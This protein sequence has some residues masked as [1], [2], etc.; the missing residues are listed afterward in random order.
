MKVL[1]VIPAR[2]PSARLPGKP[3]III[4]G[5]TLLQRVYEQASQSKLITK[6]VIS[7]DDQRIIDHAKSFGALA[8]KTSDT[9]ISGSDR[10]AET[11]QILNQ[12]GEQFDLIINIQGDLPLIDPLVIDQVIKNFSAVSNNFDLGTIAKKL[13]DQ[14]EYNRSSSVK[15]SISNSNKALYFSRAPIPLI[16]DNPGQLPDKVYHHYGLYIFTPKALNAFKSLPPGYLESVEGLE[17]LRALENDLSIHVQTFD[18]L[19]S[20]SFMEVNLPE[21][22][23]AVEN[24]LLKGI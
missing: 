17:Q 21:D 20:K 4:A 15:V 19:D 6:L 12:A 16:R 9:L 11:M 23:K 13:T 18:H 2:F 1:G 22:V 14:I 10:V 24:V 5:K 7:T 8:V 3:L